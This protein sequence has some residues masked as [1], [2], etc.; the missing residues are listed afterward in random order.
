[1]A[2]REMG[3]TS[4]IGSLRMRVDRHSRCGFSLIELMVVLMLIGIMTAIIIPQMKGTFEDALLRST[5]RKL[6]DIFSLASSRAVTLNE[7]HS[8]RLE[9]KTGRYLVE[10]TTSAEKGR[11]PHPLAEISGGEGNLDT[12]VTV[13][14]RKAAD[15]QSEPLGEG[16]AFVPAAEAG[17]RTKAQVISFYPDGTA[18]AAEILLRDRQGFRLALRINPITARIRIIELERE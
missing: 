17:S 14:V 4:A 18:D 8:V 6:V 7:S 3:P 12:R 15:D 13:E 16:P 5:A 9:R 11:D 1:M 10:R 2:V